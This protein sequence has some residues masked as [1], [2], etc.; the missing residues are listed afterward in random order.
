MVDTL[1]PFL[2]K[3]TLGPRS[4]VPTKMFQQP[5]ADVPPPPK[6]F[7]PGK[8]RDS[9]Y[10]TKTH[11]DG[12]ISYMLSNNGHADLP[13]P[14]MKQWDPAKNTMTFFV[15][16]KVVLRATLARI[17]DKWKAAIYEYYG[18]PS[19]PTKKTDVYDVD[20]GQV[21]VS[22]S[23]AANEVWRWEYSSS[24]KKAYAYKRAPGGN[25]TV[26]YKYVAPDMTY[27]IEMT[28]V[29]GNGDNEETHKRTYHPGTNRIIREERETRSSYMVDE[30]DFDT[31]HN[32]NYI[33]KKTQYDKM[34]RKTAKTTFPRI[35]DW[36]DNKPNKLPKYES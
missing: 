29:S 28:W 11:D 10:V 6:N 19:D 34:N 18:S 8:E 25:G 1:V 24:T 26:T 22:V 9:S 4:C 15:D 21:L 32:K 14:V 16:N 13:E 12:K 2:G 5:L 27:P 7:G 35:R 33:T 31:T 17:N 20:T 23:Q 30:Y 3:L 36:L